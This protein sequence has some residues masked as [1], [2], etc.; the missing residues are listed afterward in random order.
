MPETE[1]PDQDAI[2]RPGEAQIV[3]RFRPALLV[4]QQPAIEVFVDGIGSPFDGI[5]LLRAAEDQLRNEAE[6]LAQQLEAR[7]TAVE[8]RMLRV[9]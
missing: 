7:Q 6:R 8:P 1:K 3:V 2:L 5:R 9:N 4:G